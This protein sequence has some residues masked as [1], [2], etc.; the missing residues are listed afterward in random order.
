MPNTGRSPARTVTVG[1]LLMIAYVVTGKL[2]LRLAFAF[3]SATPIWPATGIALVAFLILG[4]QLWPAIFLGAF[5]VNVTTAGTILTSL[6]IAAGNTLEGLVGAWLVERFAGGRD[7]LSRAEGVFKFALLAA[8]ISTMVS[9]TIGVVTLYL[10]G[11]APRE[12]LA[13]IWSTWWLGDGA[14][15]LLV[16][17]VLLTWI[18]RPLGPVRWDRGLEWLALM[19]GLLVVALALFGGFPSLGTRTDGLK[20]LT[21]PF[22]TWAAAR[23]GPREASTATLLLGGIAVW[24]TL[25]LSGPAGGTT[26]NASLVQLQAYM[27]VAAVMTLMLA[28]AVAERKAAE[29]SLRAL[30]ISDPLTGIANYRHLIARM[31]A[32]IERSERTGR[33]FAVLFMDVDGLKK[34][35]DRHGHIVGSRALAR[36]AEV[37]RDSARVVDTAARYG[38]DEFALLLPETG[39]DEAAQVGR[40]LTERLAASPEVPPVQVSLGIAIHPRDG[41]TPDAL[42]GAADRQ[43]YHLRSRTRG[44]P[45]ATPL[46]PPQTS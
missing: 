21:I 46:A 43:L 42:I 24:G 22:L 40:R 12:T 1:L 2:G 3:P 38:G 27:A 13:T 29:A 19:G 17:P 5:L 23:F 18:T 33:P 35:N 34:I 44:E 31:E 25:R 7:C 10:A 8:L 28:A 30:A 26:T 20:F 4:R 15:D 6:G 11:L 9:A 41:A 36:V 37:L 16:A 32:E 14:G 45:L 39:A